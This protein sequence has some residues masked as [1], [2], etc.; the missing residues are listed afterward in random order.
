MTARDHVLPDRPLK[1]HP[2]FLLVSRLWGVA[3]AVLGLAALVGYPLWQLDE[4]QTILSDQRIWETGV[5]AV[6]AGVEGHGTTHN[7]LLH[8]YHLT[9]DYTDLEGRDHRHELSFESLSAVNQRAPVEVRYDPQAPERFA[10]SWAVHMRGGRWGSFAFLGGMGLVIGIVM[11]FGARTVFRRM[12]DARLC[13]ALGSEEIEL[14]LA[15][16]VEVRQH[17][18][19]TGHVKYRYLVPQ[20]SG[21]DATHEVIFNRKKKQKPLYADPSETRVLALRSPK[22]PH[23]PVVLRNDLYPFQAPAGAL[24]V[25]TVRLARRAK[26]AEPPQSA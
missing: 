8:S 1:V 26:A 19:A 11:V 15:A 23:R 24:E 10:L 21:K 3:C 18:R 12:G 7:F 14:P 13:A 16:V 2:R 6:G 9:V 17:G 20:P 5:P 4:A 22:V 25:V